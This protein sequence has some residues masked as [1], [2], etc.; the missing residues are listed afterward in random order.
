[1]AVERWATGVRLLFV[2]SLVLSL[3]ACGER[4]P[5][6]ASRSVPHRPRPKLWAIE[7]SGESDA[8]REIQ[9]CADQRLEAG[10]ASITP[11][12]SGR[13]CAQEGSTAGI[14]P[15]QSYKCR[16]NGQE[17]GVATSVSGRYPEDFTAS[18]TVVDLDDLRSVYSRSLHFS[19][20]GRCPP[21]WKVGQATNQAGKRVAA[22]FVVSTNTV[23][24]GQ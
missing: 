12:I 21:G 22:A 2:A 6:E 7:V 1:M 13:R 20:L 3:S 19:H 15:N 4:Q 14:P 5:F 16:I 18:S 23:Y 17:F 24:Q 11:E 10:F 8:G 9:L